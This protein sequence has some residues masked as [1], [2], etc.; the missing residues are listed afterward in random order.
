MLP[1]VKSGE[2]LKLPES[3]KAHGELE[4][5]R[6]TQMRQGEKDKEKHS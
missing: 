1:F 3:D 6:K 5:F 2:M 4:G